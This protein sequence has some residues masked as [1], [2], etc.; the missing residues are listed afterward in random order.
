MRTV[1]ELA[2]MVAE[3][4]QAMTEAGYTLD[5][6]K[7]DGESLNIKSG[8]C[9]FRWEREQQGYGLLLVI[10]ERDRAVHLLQH[11]ASQR[12]S[13]ARIMEIVNAA[14]EIHHALK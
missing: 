12:G 1:Y 3:I 11:H 14:L 13:L 6:H 5:D 8:K 10:H 2:E 9:E 7:Y 4:Q